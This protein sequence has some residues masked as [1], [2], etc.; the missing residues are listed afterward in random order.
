MAKSEFALSSFSHCVILVFPLIRSTSQFKYIC[1]VRALKVGQNDISCFY[2][3][4]LS[5]VAILLLE[6]Q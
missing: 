2:I 3:P 1:I 5:E 4:C 6:Q